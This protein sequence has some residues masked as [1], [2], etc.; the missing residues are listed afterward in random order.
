MLSALVRGGSS[1]SN[2]IEPSRTTFS[3]ST[4]V[5]GGSAR[6]THPDL[7]EVRCG[8]TTP[9]ARELA[10]SCYGAAR[11]LVEVGSVYIEQ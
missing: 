10:R 11:D 9:N 5:R 3:Q 2:L 8:R 4:V 7:D 6:W 1:T